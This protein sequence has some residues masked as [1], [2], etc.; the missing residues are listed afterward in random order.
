MSRY[1]GFSRRASIYQ[2][3]IDMPKP[4]AGEPQRYRVTPNHPDLTPP[5]QRLG[6]WFR[7]R[8]VRTLSRPV[9]RAAAN[10]LHAKVKPP[11][12]VVR[13]PLKLLRL[14][15]E[16]VT[17]WAKKHF[18]EW[19][20]PS[21]LI[22][23]CRKPSDTDQSE[24]LPPDREEPWMSNFDT[25]IL[26][27]EKLKDLQGITIPKFL[28]RTTCNGQQA[29]LIQDI[30]GSYLS[31]PEGATLTYDEVRDLLEQCYKELADYDAIQTDPSTRNFVLV[32]DRQRLM[33]VD[34]EFMAIGYPEQTV[35]DFDTIAS[36]GSALRRYLGLQK[37]FR[38]EGL[39]E[40][41]AY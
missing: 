5:R 41:A 23:K 34:L 7:T 3:H 30:P 14:L 19:F 1:P 39:L 33:T 25:E 10:L 35:T 2:A 12:L 9:H 24:F 4:Y 21:T 32:P 38:E 36:Q 15:P 17:I 22:V 8:F 11:P 29:M 26:A 28:G 16:G 37:H 13:L 27:Y 40:P 20:L 18:P 31:N 6:F